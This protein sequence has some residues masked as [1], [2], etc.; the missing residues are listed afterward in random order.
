MD[1]S[2]DR[3]GNLRAE[4]RCWSFHGRGNSFDRY[5]ESTLNDIE[6][7][8]HLLIVDQNNFQL[9]QLS[10]LLQPLREDLLNG[11]GFVLLKG[12]PV[13]QWG[14]R[15]S[16]IAYMGLGTYLGYSVSQNCK[17]HV[18]GHV[19][20]LGDDAKQ[21]DR[22][23]IYRTNARYHFPSQEVRERATLELTMR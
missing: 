18:L 5:L 23:R 9:P 12:F 14:N 2:I 3:R 13:E 7:A 17:G 8:R 20:D 15:K 10:I 4:R 21:I 16:A 6:Y 22:V 1:T 11:K 19:K